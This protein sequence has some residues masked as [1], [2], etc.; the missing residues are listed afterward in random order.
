MKIKYTVKIRDTRSY[1]Y[2]YEE[3]LAVGKK[4]KKHSFYKHPYKRRQ[5]G[6]L[7][8]DSG[9]VRESGQKSNLY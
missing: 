1:G 4:Y 3:A 9:A 2:L 6:D 7:I 5:V 8:S